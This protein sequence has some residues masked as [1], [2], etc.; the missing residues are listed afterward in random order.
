MD[1]GVIGFLLQQNRLWTKMP[2][3][4]R[5]PHSRQAVPSQPSGL[6][7]GRAKAGHH[8]E[9]IWPWKAAARAVAA[10][11]ALG[12]HPERCR[13]LLGKLWKLRG[14]GGDLAA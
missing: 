5:Q 10:Q 6:S 12:W 3:S 14:S 9:R 1:S 2:C 13:V 7:Q 8:A 11:V 4:G